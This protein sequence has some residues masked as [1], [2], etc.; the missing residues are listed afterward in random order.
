MRA[1]TVPAVRH[2]AGTPGGAL[3]RVS[4]VVLGAAACA[5]CGAGVSCEASARPSGACAD[6]TFQHRPYVEWRQVHPHGILQ[7]VGDAFYPACTTAR[8]CRSDPL[9]GMGA[10]D[11]WQY[12]DIDSSRAVIG[13]RQDTHTYVVFVRVGVDPGSLRTRR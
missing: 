9:D 8:S 12:A 7:E 13:L 10:T 2:R 5:A 11:V 3:R 6:L 1:T 4:V